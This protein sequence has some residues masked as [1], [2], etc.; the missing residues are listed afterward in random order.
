MACEEQ[1]VPAG[2]APRNRVHGGMLVR[3]TSDDMSLAYKWLKYSIDRKWDRHSFTLARPSRYGFAG[4]YLIREL[5]IWLK[6]R[7]QFFDA[8][9][10]SPDIPACLEES[11]V[12][13]SNHVFA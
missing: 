6:K 3:R 2:L 9:L 12:F 10:E 11:P 5:P 13:P 8:S 7:F 1:R 4:F